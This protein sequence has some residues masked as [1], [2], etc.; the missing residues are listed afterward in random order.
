MV[1]SCV[2]GAWAYGS[3]IGVRRVVVGGGR[4]W[5][6]QDIVCDGYVQRAG[7]EAKSSDGGWGGL[8]EG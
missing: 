2:E 7:Q 3:S 1:W 5:V 8:G 4:L 6:N